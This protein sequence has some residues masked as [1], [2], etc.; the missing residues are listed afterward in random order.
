MKTQVINAIMTVKVE[1]SD[2]EI[3]AL[4][5]GTKFYHTKKLTVEGE[6]V[7]ENSSI[8]VHFIITKRE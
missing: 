7:E 4:H 5:H 2:E 8:D 3:L 6:A 1:L